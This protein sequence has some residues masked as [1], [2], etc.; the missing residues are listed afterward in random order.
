MIGQGEAMRKTILIPLFLVLIWM[1]SAADSNAAPR[2]LLYLKDGG[3]I[4]CQSY[5]RAKGLVIVK[6]NRDLVVELAREE[7]DMKKS[8]PA[9]HGRKGTKPQVAA[10]SA[11]R[12]TSG[13]LPVNPTP[14]SGKAATGTE[15]APVSVSGKP[16]PAGP[17]QQPA[18]NP[19]PVKASPSP[20][21][22]PKPVSEPTP[23]PPPVPEVVEV[24]T[25]IGLTYLIA[26]IALFLIIITS[27][28]KV[29]E[30]A[31][32]A[33]WKSLVPIYNLFLLVEISGKPW[34]WFL[35]LFIPL[36]N[37]IIAI[38]VYIALAERF[39]KGALFG[40]G[41][42]FL[43]FIFFPVLAFDKSSYN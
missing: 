5:Y 33:G 15:K 42:A 25:G 32:V 9:K 39:G 18:A 43:G 7:V 26:G 11:N 4:E 34:W 38:L 31:G 3:I 20:P 12:S 41:L 28:W 17:G 29:F 30:K 14:T 40:L 35:L 10:A 8:F 6:I 1:M 22:S 37:F 13:I 23:T 24:S 36:V 21:S 27:F 2:K 19:P 16:S